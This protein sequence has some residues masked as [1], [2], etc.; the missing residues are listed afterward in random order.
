M[1][2]MTEEKNEARCPMCE[3][4]LKDALNYPLVKINNVERLPLPEHARGRL[5]TSGMSMAPEG[6]WK[7]FSR[8]KPSEILPPKVQAFFEGA[9]SGVKEFAFDGSLYVRHYKEGIDEDELC[10]V[11][12]PLDRFSRYEDIQPPFI[13]TGHVGDYLH[14]LE[15]L[16][17]QTVKTE[18]FF[19]KRDRVSRNLEGYSLQLSGAEK[20]PCMEVV[21]AVSHIKRRDR[22]LQ[23]PVPDRVCKLAKLDI[24][25]K[26]NVYGAGK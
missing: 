18:E 9:R 11:E 19:D 24:E 3:Y 1:N 15:S 4:E 23:Y 5:I 12:V 17:G 26:L 20:S 22:R 21:L 2:K 13:Q 10:S 6:L 7:L 25:G 16:V 14:W 8:K